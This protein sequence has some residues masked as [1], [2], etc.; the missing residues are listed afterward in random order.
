MKRIIIFAFLLAVVTL[1]K[2]QAQEVSQPNKPDYWGTFCLVSQ[3]I[4]DTNFFKVDLTELPSE[5]EKVY[6]KCY[7]LEQDVFHTQ[8]KVYN[9]EKSEAMIAVPK[10]YSVEDYRH[11]MATMKKMTQAANY[12]FTL[13][14]K[15]NYI[16]NHKSTK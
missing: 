3:T 6:F 14:Q 15:E 9:I 8:I 5:F 10:K 1:N 2:M 4:K 7:Y 13:E 16:L 11:F 12:N